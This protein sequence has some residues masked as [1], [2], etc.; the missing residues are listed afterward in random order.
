MHS[1][2]VSFI[3][4]VRPEDCSSS[5]DN[6]D[7]MGS[8][9]LTI[10]NRKCQIWSMH[11][12]A[13]DFD[14]IDGLDDAKNFCRNTKGN[15]KKE[16][17]FCFT[18]I[19]SNE[20][21]YCQLKKCNGCSRIHGITYGSLQFNNRQIYSDRSYQPGSK[22]NFFC[23]KNFAIHDPNSGSLEWICREDGQWSV[24]K[25]PKC[26]WRGFI[27][28]FPPNCWFYS[29]N[30][31][32]DSLPR[33]LYYGSTDAANGSQCLEWQKIDKFNDEDFYQE[34]LKNAN[35][36]CRSPGNF[37]P[38]C[39]TDSQ[40]LTNCQ[41]PQCTGCGSIPYIKY[42]SY[43]ITFIPNTRENTLE[44]GSFVNYRCSAGDLV[45]NSKLTCSKGKWDGELPY[46]DVKFCSNPPLAPKN[47]LV[48]Y[49][50]IFYA[51]IEDFGKDYLAYD[52][53]IYKFKCKTT[54]KFENPSINE[55]VYQCMKGEW[56]L[57]GSD[58]KCIIKDDAIN[59]PDEF[60]PFPN[61][62]EN[63][64]RNNV[65]IIKK[66]KD[67]YFGTFEIV[68]FK[69]YIVQGDPLV[70]CVDGLWT[71]YPKCVLE[72]SCSLDV[73]NKPA[74]NVKIISSSLYYSPDNSGIAIGSKVNYECL[75]GYQPEFTDDDLK[76]ECLENGEWSSR[77][78]VKCLMVQTNF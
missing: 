26:L 21:E 18:N 62:V 35:N 52:E 2:V 14:F 28:S 36:Y 7:Y 24:N 11:P 25:L 37:E 49:K 63:A 22:I 9:S 33:R 27:D 20:W 30:E 75:P 73:L 71:K 54:F 29:N 42:T 13:D 34:G 19:D 55:L 32:V 48:S 58:S 67:R 17:A 41:I 45:G 50:R 44:T 51:N 39:F 12:Q 74:E 4:Y 69:G 70:S 61:D 77:I 64:Y 43:D 76:L 65:K 60:C 5:E 59:E 23:R 78:P 6:L 53:S 40:T 38:S 1:K 31:S 8:L 47:T 10:S 66:G 16:K 15:L 57:I 68:C 46:C 3:Q 56:K 72:P